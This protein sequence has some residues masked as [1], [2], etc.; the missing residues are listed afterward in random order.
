MHMLDMYKFQS[1]SEDNSCMTCVI[2]A[3]YCDFWGKETE[4]LHRF[5]TAAYAS[6]DCDS[7]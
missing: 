5:T 6:D 7:V 2:C 1:P 4:T 3:I